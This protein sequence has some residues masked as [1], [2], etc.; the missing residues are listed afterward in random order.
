MLFSFEIFKE[1]MNNKNHRKTIEVFFPSKIILAS[2]KNANVTYI[3][4]LH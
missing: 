3:L 2:P 4:T 1:N